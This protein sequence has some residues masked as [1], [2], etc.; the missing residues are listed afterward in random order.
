V[1]V[2]V[3]LCACVVIKR[4]AHINRQQNSGCLPQEGQERARVGMRTGCHISTT[5][6]RHTLR[7]RSTLSNYLASSRDLYAGS[8]PLKMA[9]IMKA[10]VAVLARTCKLRVDDESILGQDSTRNEFGHEHTP[11][12]WM[13]DSFSAL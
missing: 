8:A 5:R 4:Q 11:L 9:L 3:C 1:C 10:F 6:P 2:S 13:R 12:Y 7:A